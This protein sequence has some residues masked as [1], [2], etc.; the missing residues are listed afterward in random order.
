MKKIDKNH[1]L[2]RIREKSKELGF[3]DGFKLVYG[4]WE[5]LQSASTVFLSLNPG[6]WTPDD[7]DS[8]EEVSDE[9][10]NSYLVE[11]NTTNSPITKQFLELMNLL[12]LEPNNVLTGVVVPFRTHTWGE[13]TPVQKKEA[14]RIAMEFWSVPLMKPSVDRI[15][16]CSNQARDMVVKITRAE[17]LQ[18]I[19]ANWDKINLN[20][21]RTIDGKKKIFH[22]P[23]LSRFKLLSRP[24]SITALRNLFSK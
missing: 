16:V 12:E 8:K 3:N 24:A 13:L 7:F 6:I 2:D 10:G 18:S 20:L 5:T 19:P 17:L 14:Q 15:I 4:K 9:R 23:Q 22:L 11:K 21:Y 1:W